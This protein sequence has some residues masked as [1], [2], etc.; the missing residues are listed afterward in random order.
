MKEITTL[1]VIMCVYAPITV[2]FI[3]YAI[4]LIWGWFNDNT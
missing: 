1:I 2:V 3:V 4:L